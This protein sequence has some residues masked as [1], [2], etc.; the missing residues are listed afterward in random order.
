MAGNQ[1]QF[2]PGFFSTFSPAN[3]TKTWPPSEKGTPR[4][5]SGGKTKQLRKR[6]PGGGS[7]RFDPQKNRKPPRFILV[8]FSSATVIVS[9][10]RQWRRRPASNSSPAHEPIYSI[11]RHCG[12]VLNDGRR[13][14]N[15]RRLEQLLLGGRDATLWGRVPNSFLSEITF[16]FSLFFTHVFFWG[17]GCS[18]ISL[19]YQVDAGLWRPV[20]RRFSIC[21][22]ID[23]VEKW[24]HSRHLLIAKIIIKLHRCTRSDMML[25]NL[26]YLHV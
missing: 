16:Q 8:F 14:W 15:T 9:M 20:N 4:Q 13:S 3:E 23:L 18:M 25:L 1:S 21:L 2:R 22:K 11:G 7:F 19:R 24:T 17:G 6:K 12:R 5:P 10:S 26:K